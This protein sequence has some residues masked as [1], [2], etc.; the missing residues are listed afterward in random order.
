MVRTSLFVIITTFFLATTIFGFQK[1]R[2]VA[3]VLSNTNYAHEYK[4]GAYFN[5]PTPDVSLTLSKLGFEVI[6]SIEPTKDLL[7]SRMKEFVSS[8]KETDV[9]LIYYSGRMV[10]ASGRNYLIPTDLSRGQL[11]DPELNG[12]ALDPVLYEMERKVRHSFVFLNAC[13]LDLPEYGALF[14]RQMLRSCRGL[15]PLGTDSNVVVTHASLPSEKIIS[16]KKNEAIFVKALTSNLLKADMQVHE[17]LQ[18]V[19]RDVHV[20]TKA[21][22][23]PWSENGSGKRFV[24]HTGGLPY[25]PKEVVQPKMASILPVSLGRSSIDEEAQKNIEKLARK[26]D[27]IK[28]DSDLKRIA[29]N[30]PDPERFIAEQKLLVP[31][32]KK[33]LKM[34]QRTAIRG[35][36]KKLFEFSCYRGRIDGIWGK[37]SRRAVSSFKRKIKNRK[38]KRLPDVQLYQAVSAY[39]GPVCGRPCGTDKRLNKSRQCQLVV[40]NELPFVPVITDNPNA[41][42]KRAAKKRRYKTVKRY[43]GKKRYRRKYSRSARKYKKRYVRYNKKRRYGKRKKWRQK[44]KY[45]RKYTRYNKRKKYRGKRYAKRYKRKRVAYYQ[46]TRRNYY[47]GRGW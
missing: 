8:L 4:N 45:S 22:Q 47:R 11:L 43:R 41:S 32:D 7:I 20:A 9:A 16:H 3:L 19:Y 30:L 25:D 29:L 40:K 34:D 5:T 2:R 27:L 14:T 6:E 38:L 23:T 28:E 42:K 21:R 1:E 18:N 36:Q 46:G 24:F 44:R 39:E 15:K 10:Q 26:V 31:N 12:V 35:I 37:R 33:Q 13:R 17:V